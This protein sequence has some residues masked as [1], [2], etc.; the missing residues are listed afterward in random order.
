MTESHMRLGTNRL[1]LTG[2]L[3]FL[4]VLPARGQPATKPATRPTTA[5]AKSVKPGNAATAG[6][7]RREAK[8]LKW[9]RKVET[10]LRREAQTQERIAELQ[11]NGLPR[12]A[13]RPT[14][15]NPQQLAED[16][17]WNAN[18]QQKDNRHRRLR[19]G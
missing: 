18:W 15:A 13:T 19:A 3:G 4:L 12:P 8:E 17:D 6:M 9:K 14:A 5:P 10:G 7:T 11:K 1:L 2:V 16:F